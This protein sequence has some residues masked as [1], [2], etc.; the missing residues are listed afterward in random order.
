[1]WWQPGHRHSLLLW[2]N[3]RANYVLQTSRYWHPTV[4]TEDNLGPSCK[5]NVSFW[6]AS[7]LWLLT[8]R[9]TRDSGRQGDMSGW[10]RTELCSYASST[11]DELCMSDQVIPPL[12]A[13]V[14]LCVQ[15]GLIVSLFL[16]FLSRCREI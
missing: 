13:P 5:E 6:E 15:G 3:V 8:P 9:W 7:S 11:L 1:M 10:R 16:E 2:K 4:N 14:P 12:C